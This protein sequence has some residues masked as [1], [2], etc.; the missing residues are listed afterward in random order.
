MKWSPGTSSA[1]SLS[2][3]SVAYSIPTERTAAGSSRTARMRSARSGGKVALLSCANLSICRTFVTGMIS[4]MIGVSQPAA[5]HA[6]PQPQVVLRAEEHLGDRVVGAGPALVHEVPHVGVPVGGPRVHLGERGDT[7]AEV[8]R[9]LDQFDQLGGVSETLGVPHPLPHGVARRVAA[10]RQHVADARVGVLTDDA[11]QL[12]A[13]VADGGQVGDG[14]ERGLG[15]D[16]LGG[17]DRALTRGAARTVGH[18]HEGRRVGLD[19]P[20]RVPERPLALLRAR[21][22]ELER[23]RPLAGRHE[24]PDRRRVVGA[25]GR[26]SKGHVCRLTGRA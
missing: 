2:H 14:R 7:D 6:V 23:V 1:I 26:G 9:L 17:A 12:G 24:L 8:A 20:Q 13:R 3:S 4:G 10:Q 19:A 11:A 16:P 21:R 5:A 22:E 15:G 18:R 25:G